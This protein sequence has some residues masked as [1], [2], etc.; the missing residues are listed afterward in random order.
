MILFRSHTS[1]KQR[2]LWTNGGNRLCPLQLSFIQ[3]RFHPLVLS[4]LLNHQY[5]S[6]NTMSLQQLSSRLVSLSLYPARRTLSSTSVLARYTTAASTPASSPSKIDLSNLSDNPG[7]KSQVL[8][9]PAWMMPNRN[10]I[11]FQ[12]SNQDFRFRL[13]RQFNNVPGIQS[14]PTKKTEPVFNLLG[15]LLF[16]PSIASPCRSWSGFRKGSY[17]CSWSQGSKGPFRKRCPAQARFRGW[18]DSYH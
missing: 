16:R 10:L 14:N 6:K 3:L 11:S 18:S 8:P 7:S 5:I 15:K 17:R 12:S 13:T 4:S 1:G 2:P 9:D